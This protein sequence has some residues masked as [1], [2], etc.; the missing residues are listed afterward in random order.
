[1]GRYGVDY[2]G[3][4]VKMQPAPHRKICPATASC[5][6][7]EV[8]TISCGRIMTPNDDGPFIWNKEFDPLRKSDDSLPKTCAIWSQAA[9]DGHWHGKCPVVIHSVST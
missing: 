5:K 2:N 8:F 1:M 3:A 6:L 7:S 9:W 4:L